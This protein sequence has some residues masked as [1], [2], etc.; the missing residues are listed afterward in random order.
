[1]NQTADHYTYTVRWSVE[2]Q[3]YVATVAE[4]PSL[5]W[6]DDDP[7]N[8][9]AGIQALSTQVIEDLASNN[10][11]VPQPYAERKYSGKFVT[12]VPPEMHRQLAIDAAAQHVS[13]NRLVATRLAAKA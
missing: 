11:P 12:R 13:L 4:L 3:E 8:A 10:E 7:S 9:I 5:S 1:M 6:L 2:D